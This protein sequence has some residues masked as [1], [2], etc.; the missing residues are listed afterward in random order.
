MSELPSETN[1]TGEPNIKQA[2]I[3]SDPPPEAS[4]NP[5][6]DQV[7]DVEGFLKLLRVL[8][9]Y[10]KFQRS[11]FISRQAQAF[12]QRKLIFRP[13]SPLSC[14][15]TS[16][17][18][19]FRHGTQSKSQSI[20]ED[21]RMFSLLYL[22]LTLWDYR[23]DLPAQENFLNILALQLARHEV[24]LH[25]LAWMFIFS[26]Y[27]FPDDSVQNVRLLKVSRIVQI[28]KRRTPM[29]TTQVN[30]LLLQF[31]LLEPHGEGN[32][33]GTSSSWDEK[34]FRDSLYQDISNQ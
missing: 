14:I 29:F 1:P 15:L 30:T 31:L 16:E 11:Q 27:I 2:Q 6:D 7:D 19:Q 25:A 4:D 12:L 26:G 3:Y 24:N 21:C 5:R 17:K 20:Q 13:G 33:S 22:N 10:A 8:G 32:T 9:L 28:L 23:H 34:A 18:A